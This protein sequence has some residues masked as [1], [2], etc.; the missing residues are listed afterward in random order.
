MLQTKFTKAQWKE[1]L[2]WNGDQHV[3]AYSS[4]QTTVR[5]FLAKLESNHRR[6]HQRTSLQKPGSWNH[7]CWINCR[8][9]RII[10][11]TWS[12]TAQY[13]QQKMNYDY[14]P[15]TKSIFL[16]IRNK[17]LPHISHVY[18]NWTVRITMYLQL[19]PCVHD[20][21]GKKFQLVSVWV[22]NTALLKI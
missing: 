15:E 6:P 19:W 17:A 18:K 20:A 1:L 3:Y 7:R 21:C 8:P 2:W 11:C 5:W 4:F 12:F 10:L 9:W 16:M 22:R 13:L 14:W